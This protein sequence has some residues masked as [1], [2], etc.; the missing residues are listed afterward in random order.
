M[1]LINNELDNLKNSDIL[2]FILF[3]L[4]KL[5][6]SNEYSAIS[7]LAYILDKEN[8][9]KLCEY[10]GGLTITIPTVDD[11]EIL[12]NSLL[13]YKYIDI[14]NNNFEEAYSNLK[15]KIDKSE[16]KKCYLKIKEVLQDY[17]ISSRGKI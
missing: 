4:F 13:L 16:V 3:T 1:G 11:L 8:L 7:E 9:F 2:S 5:R 10:F 15:D 14:D 12:L 6:E 17:S